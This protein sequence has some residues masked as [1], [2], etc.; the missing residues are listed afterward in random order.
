M[1]TPTQS[2][3]LEMSGGTVKKAGIG[4]TGV[5]PAT[6]NATDAA[7]ALVGSSLEGDAVEAAATAAAAV[8]QPKSDHRGSADYKRHVVATFVRRILAQIERS[9]QKVA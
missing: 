1:R 8:S 7:A 4:L 2:I 3:A 6:V 9:Q 5:G